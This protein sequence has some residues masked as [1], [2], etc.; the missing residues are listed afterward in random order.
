MQGKGNINNKSEISTI[1]FCFKST[2]S[3]RG[4]QSYKVKVFSQVF[5]ERAL[6]ESTL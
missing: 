2:R 5:P 4:K 3:L 1:F 6:F